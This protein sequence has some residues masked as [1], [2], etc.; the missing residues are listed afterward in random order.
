[1]SMTLL[2]LPRHEALERV[3][4]GLHFRPQFLFAGVLGALLLT[5]A[6]GCHHAAAPKE[7]KRIEVTVTTPVMDDDVIDY[8]DFTG[9]L[10]ALKTVDIRARVSGYITEVPF[11]E[12][13][14]VH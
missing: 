2:S 7:Q 6:A 10:D 1:M 4:R 3:P 8:Q 9:R 5:L 14:L 12:G 13:D 11:K